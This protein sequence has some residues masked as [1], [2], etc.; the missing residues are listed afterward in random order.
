MLS[1]PG[2]ATRPCELPLFRRHGDCAKARARRAR[3]GRAPQLLGP[4]GRWFPLDGE[5]GQIPPAR[6]DAEV[7]GRRGQA[8]RGAEGRKAIRGQAREKDLSFA[9]IVPKP[10]T[11]PNLK[12][13][14]LALLLTCDDL[15]E[16]PAGKGPSSAPKGGAP[17]QELRVASNG[18]EMWLNRAWRVFSEVIPRAKASL[19][20]EAFRTCQLV[21]FSGLS[22]LLGQ[23]KRC[24][25]AT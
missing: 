21:Q 11:T 15:S 14:G 22:P 10:Q 24:A 9:Y 2:Q 19:A 23:G 4:F 1:R 3:R 7:Q 8:R 17:T 18:D 13:F 6:V 25:F 12:P 16:A 20:D 5:P